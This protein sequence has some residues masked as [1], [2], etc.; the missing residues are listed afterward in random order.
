MR[1]PHPSDQDAEPQ[2]GPGSAPGYEGR[3]QLEALSGE[4]SPLQVQSMRL[5]ASQLTQTEP[6][7]SVPEWRRKQG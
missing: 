6:Q 5:G 3:W 4:G 7:E 1:M 2:T